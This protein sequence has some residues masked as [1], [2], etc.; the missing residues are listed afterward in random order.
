M[1]LA[2]DETICAAATALGG[3]VALLRLSGERAQQVAE[4][5]GFA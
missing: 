1:L 3:E 5:S 2:P 4:R